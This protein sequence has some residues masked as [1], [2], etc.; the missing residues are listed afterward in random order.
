MDA[1]KSAVKEIGELLVARDYRQ[2]RRITAGV[3]L[4]EDEIQKA[5]SEYGRTLVTP[6]ESGYDVLDAIEV[7]SPRWLGIRQWSIVLPLWTE[8]EGL[9]DLSVEL[10][11]FESKPIRIELDNIH[12]R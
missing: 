5:I 11:V 8:E 4:S 9:S 10:T 7:K 3:R 2:V 6:P 1:I 12:V